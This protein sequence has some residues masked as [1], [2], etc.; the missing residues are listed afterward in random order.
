M[1]EQQAEKNQ[2]KSESQW[3]TVLDRY[4]VQNQPQLKIE[5]GDEYGHFL[6]SMTNDAT[7]MLVEM[8][9]EG[10][11]PTEARQVVLAGMLEEIDH[12]YLTPSETI[13]PETGDTQT[14]I[15]SVED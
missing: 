7:E 8:I 9:Q 4:V 10:M 1:D 3:V 2:P 14:E 5:Y 15:S 6:T 12:A 13:P 11:D